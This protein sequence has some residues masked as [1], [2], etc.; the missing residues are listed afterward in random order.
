MRA[1]HKLSYQHFVF[2]EY[3]R[4]MGTVVEKIETKDEFQS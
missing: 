3:I 2:V 4:G 1:E